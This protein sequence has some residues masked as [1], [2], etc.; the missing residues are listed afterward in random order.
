MVHVF[1]LILLEGDVGGAA[2]SSTRDFAFVGIRRARRPA[3]RAWR[4]FTASYRTRFTSLTP[5]S[6]APLPNGP[7]PALS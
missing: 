5:G 4:Y 7:L 1:G 3:Y 2:T 6:L